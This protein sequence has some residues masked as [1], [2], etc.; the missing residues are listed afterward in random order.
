MPVLE[1]LTFPKW[2]LDKILNL[3]IVFYRLKNVFLEENN[4]ILRRVSKVSRGFYRHFKSQH[5]PAMLA[6]PSL[7]RWVGKNWPQ[8]CGLSCTGSL[9][10]AG[11][12]PL[13]V[14][15]C[16]MQRG[17]LLVFCVDSTYMLHFLFIYQH[18]STEIWIL[19]CW[20]WGLQKD[21]LA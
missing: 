6:K 14:H 12:V 19:W 20:I 1:R 18:M 11:G 15:S 3:E 17:L 8:L 7:L 16:C 10:H 21:K 13:A 5:A 2:K 4:D 9:V